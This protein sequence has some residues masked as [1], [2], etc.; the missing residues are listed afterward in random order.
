MDSMYEILM[1]LPLFK[2]VSFNKIS[3]IVEMVKFHF[4]KFSAGDVI[5]RADEPCTHIK[6]V[7]SGAVKLVMESRDERMRITQSL[8]APA[9][10]SPDFMFGRSTVYP[11]TVIAATNNCGLVQLTKSDYLKVIH[12]DEIF[13]FNILNML[14]RN[15]QKA[16]HGVL[17]LTSG[18]LEGRIAFWIV[19]T[20]QTGS[21]DIILE[22]RHRD[23]YTLFGV[24][25][26]VFYQTLQEMREKSLL[27]YSP[28]EIR[29][30]SRRDM[31]ELL[32]RNL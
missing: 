22:C 1:D 20:T 26:S 15:A 11:A 30:K 9:V 6:F 8:K 3:E 28:N 13:M 14:S 2:G 16:T 29:V 5:V 10:I 21:E 32:L 7:I 12:N 24:P 23:L 4:L 18:S 27:D 25:R 31:T 17:A 19:A